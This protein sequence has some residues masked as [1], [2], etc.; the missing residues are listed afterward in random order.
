MF[1]LTLLLHCSCS[2]EKKGSGKPKKTFQAADLRNMHD[3]LS[4]NMYKIRQ[5]VRCQV[6]Q[7]PRSR[8]H[9]S[10]VLASCGYFWATCRALTSGIDA[11]GR[12]AWPW[13]AG[14]GSFPLAASH[15]LLV[16]SANAQ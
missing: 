12:F 4:K 7:P 11:D 3:I 16:E 9:V 1:S 5:R 8:I 13:A 2:E 10:L 14:D 6:I 15:H